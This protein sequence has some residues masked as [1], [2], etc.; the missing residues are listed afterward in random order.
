MLMAP[1]PA[2]PDLTKLIPRAPKQPVSLSVLVSL[3]SD[4]HCGPSTQP[5]VE[6][7]DKPS[8]H[9]GFVLGRGILSGLA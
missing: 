3:M 1:S 8:T 4:S 7:G 9:P 6:S 5:G 2:A